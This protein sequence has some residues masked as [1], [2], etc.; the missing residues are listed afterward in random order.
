MGPVTTPNLRQLKKPI[1]TETA[2]TALARPPVRLHIYIWI[3]NR[4]RDV[5]WMD[6][7]LSV[8]AASPIRSI[9][10]GNYQ[11]KGKTPAPLPTIRRP[12]CESTPRQVRGAE[13]LRQG[14]ARRGRL[15][16]AALMSNGP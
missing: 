11:D 16:K 10:I 5:L 1:R 7:L 12:S 14:H 4:P 15:N 8:N 13:V 3:A 6:T 9:S 2:L